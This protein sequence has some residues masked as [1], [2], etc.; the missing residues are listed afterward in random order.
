MSTNNYT[1]LAFLSAIGLYNFVFLS[2]V[3]LTVSTTGISADRRD[4]F[5][6][7][8]W[9]VTIEVKDRIAYMPLKFVVCYYYFKYCH[10]HYI[11][12]LYVIDMF[13]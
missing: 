2:A 9:S 10:Y 4:V 11:L 13:Y 5:L 8:F 7:K 6:S 12:F 3:E 1:I